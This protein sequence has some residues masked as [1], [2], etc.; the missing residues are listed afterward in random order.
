MVYLIN[1]ILYDDID[2]HHTLSV[3]YKYDIFYLLMYLITSN[4][5]VLHMWIRHKP[6]KCTWD[7]LHIPCT[8]TFVYTELMY[9]KNLPLLRM[10]KSVFLNYRYMYYLINKIP[11]RDEYVKMISRCIS[12]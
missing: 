7:V 1:H 5:D 10:I 12:M 9:V 2:C 4:T 3:T 8:N 11:C 6:I